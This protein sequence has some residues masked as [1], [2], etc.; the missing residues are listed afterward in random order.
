MK[1]SKLVIL[2]FLFSGVFSNILEEYVNRPDSSY[3]YTLH[4]SFN[5]T[6]GIAYVL[7][8]TSQT[9]LSTKEV[10]H[11]IWR[12]WVLIAKPNRL[13]HFKPL[14]VIAGGSSG[15][16]APN[17]IPT[18]YA[19]MSSV[20]ESILV[21]LF[22]I[23]YQPVS[24]PAAPRPRVEDGNFKFCLSRYNCVYMENVHGYW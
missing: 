18:E 12:H 10:S 15:N 19:M 4:S 17:S 6:G 24:F 20:T 22:Q 2:V 16:R 1:F 3:S 23:P 5:Y 21:M 8:V 7:N 11:P 9:W 13:K 14:F